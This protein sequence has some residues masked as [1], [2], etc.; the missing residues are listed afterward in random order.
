M[1]VCDVVQDG[2]PYD[3]GLFFVEVSFVFVLF[4]CFVLCVCVCVRLLYCRL[5]MDSVGGGVSF[6]FVSYP[7]D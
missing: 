6:S 2:T 5:R 4:L 3:G 7:L 1:Y